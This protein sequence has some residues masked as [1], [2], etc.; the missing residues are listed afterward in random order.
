MH[1]NEDLMDVLCSGYF[2]NLMHGI[3]GHIPRK[4]IG[5]LPDYV[6]NLV[7]HAILASFENSDQVKGINLEFE[8]S[9]KSG[10]GLLWNTPTVDREGSEVPWSLVVE[11][12]SVFHAVP[13]EL[14]RP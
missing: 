6:K 2:D 1:E 3:I 8:F 10:I 14:P 11:H 9:I 4:I 13:P 12:P 7:S 5:K